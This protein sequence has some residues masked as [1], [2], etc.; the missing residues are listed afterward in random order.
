MSSEP[1]QTPME[2]LQSLGGATDGAT[3]G[4]IEGAI[5]EA[6]E[7]AHLLLATLE[8][9]IKLGFFVAPAETEIRPSDEQPSLC[10]DDTFLGDWR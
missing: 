5:R 10:E 2:T 6:I 4:T 8:D 3:K 9:Q 1:P 7:E